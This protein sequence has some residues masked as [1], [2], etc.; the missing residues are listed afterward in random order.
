MKIKKPLSP[1]NTYLSGA[2]R[3]RFFSPDVEMSVMRP[4][5]AFK[6]TRQSLL[7]NVQCTALEMHWSRINPTEHFL[8]GNFHSGNE[9]A[10]TLEHGKW[11]SSAIEWPILNY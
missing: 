8:F 4:M 10:D 3:V 1:P 2:G 6:V 11:I 9:V 7:E 5:L